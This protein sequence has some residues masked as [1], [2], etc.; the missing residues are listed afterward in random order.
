MKKKE[1]GAK[2]RSR[3]GRVEA[4]R[5]RPE[6]LG[7]T[8]SRGGINFALFSRHATAVTLAVFAPGAEAPEF[9]FPLDPRLNR[10]GDVWHAF[11]A[12][13]GPGVGY[14]YL[15]DREP[16][17]NP[18]RHRYFPGRLM[19]DPCAHA[20]VGGEAWGVPR[21]ERERR[22][23]ATFGH[24]R[25]FVI[26]E[27]FDWGDDQ[28]LNRP[29]SETVI[30]ELHVRGFTRHPSSGAARPGTYAGLVERIPYLQG[31]GVTAVELLPVYE[32]EEADTS[33]RN[34]QT[35]EELLNYWGYN[36]INFFSPNAS[37][38]ADNANGNQVREFKEMVRAFHRAGIEVILD[39]VFNH[40]AEGDARGPTFSFRGIDNSV[41]Y[42]IDPLTGEYA[43][44]SG[45]GNTVNCNHPVTR[46]LI[47]QCLH[48]WVTE[49]HVDGFRFDLASILGRG[50][51]GGV[52]S[53][54]P[55]L[56]HIAFDPV[57]AHTKIIAEA[58]DAAGLYQ[59]G[60]FPSWQRWAEWNGKF[61]D[62]LRRFV[63]SDPGMIPALANRLAGSPDVYRG[64][65]R[66]PLHSIN[67]ITCH[68][69][70]TLRDLVSYDRKHNE[71][72]GE[73]NRDGANNNHSWNCGREGETAGLDPAEA[74]RIEGLRLRQQKN[75]AALLLLSRGVPM[76]LAG[77]EFGRTQRGNNNAYCQDNEIG[78]VD[79]R[80]AERNA[81]LVRFFREL[82]RF[83][84]SFVSFR[85][86]SFEEPQDCD[87]RLSF[88]GTEPGRPD[89]S[90]E[91][92]SLA[93][94]FTETDGGREDIYL[95]A[96]AWWEPLAFT[97]PELPDGRRWRLKLDTG[98]VSPDDILEPGAE[99]ELN[100]P[101][102]YKVRSRSVVAL[103]GSDDMRDKKKL[104]DYI[105]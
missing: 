60:S 22:P 87:C 83:R 86:G 50:G 98:L 29:M 21:E 71:A 73:D 42:I 88:H 90:W 13:L 94:W 4:R 67:F 6:P 91:S 96:N 34:P 97:L 63:K 52:L 26:E 48:Y 37:Y 89:W 32:F 103:V 43:N 9:L 72:N 54:P 16:N 31:L 84:Q 11:V 65:G 68:D 55:L 99:R 77:D 53:N 45:C 49:M 20:I 2:P 14:G 59:V 36:P 95:M 27:D 35:G 56:E 10:T 12:G 30:Y 78:W 61:R 1:G 33:R 28:P 40:T 75:L 66:S 41:Y 17:N 5:G 82:I 51:D 46:E 64:S 57:L 8:L 7:A 25:G 23:E 62:D 80:L 38:A 44:Y 81:D 58:W 70:F 104:F 79:W 102:K 3:K 24:R 76:I 39:V 93:A 100:E 85:F 19:L 105:E 74:A 101:G 47:R 69:G 18:R 92:R 15:L